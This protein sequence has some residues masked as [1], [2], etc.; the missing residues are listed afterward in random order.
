MTDSTDTTAGPPA[1]VLGSP[2]RAT[3][4]N[5]RA[6]G[7]L[8][9]GVI[10]RLLRE[11]LVVRA[12]VWP[13]ILT[14]LSMFVTAAATLAWKNSP[15]IYVSEPA[16]VAPLA[17]AGFEVTVAPDPKAKMLDRRTDRAVWREN[18][19][20]ILGSTWGGP[21]T[22]KAEST[23][24][25]FV[26]ERWRLEA[27]PQVKRVRRS[28]DLRPITGYIAGVVGLLFALY[29]VVIG[30]G[31]LYRDRSSGVLETDL[32]LPVPRWVHAVARLLALS[33]VLGPALVVSL[34]VVDTLLALREMKL[35]M[36]DG[37]LAAVTGGAIGVAL[38][39]RAN[40]GRGFSAP[41]S[42]ALTLSMALI[43]LGFW[44]SS[45]GR[46]LPLVSLGSAFANQ[47]SSW[48]AVLVCAALTAAVAADF[49]RRECL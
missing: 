38:M 14:A 44:Q 1:S 15:V 26:Q 20:Y 30:A 18:G 48:V 25:T 46:H 3:P 17:E 16:L 13:G 36:F 42:Q 11:G 45:I 47:H 49:H 32:A 24:R 27:P 12:L 2:V 21:L 29:G 40:A 5:L 37:F 34:L 31:S 23:L 39:A 4:S 41:L 28:E 6:I 35:W 7:G 33:L 8:S 9:F 19:R 22:Y 43:S 10:L